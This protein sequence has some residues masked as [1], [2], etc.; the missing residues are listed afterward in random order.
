MEKPVKCD[1]E[2]SL[3]QAKDY[4]LS[5]VALEIAFKELGYEPLTNHN[6]TKLLISPA[7]T[8]IAGRLA[9]RFGLDEIIVVPLFSDDQWGLVVNWHG[10]YSNGCQ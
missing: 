10:S 7:L 6:R 8:L 3:G 4:D 2:G 5:E 9:E 1:S